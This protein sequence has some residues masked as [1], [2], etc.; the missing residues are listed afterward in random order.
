MGQFLGLMKGSVVG[1]EI[2]A[3]DDSKFCACVG[4]EKYGEEHGSVQSL[5]G[6]HREERCG[7]LW[8]QTWHVVDAFLMFPSEAGDLEED[9]S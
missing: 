5:L 4:D 7:S 3:G 2:G 6:T 8:P 1:T 9:Q